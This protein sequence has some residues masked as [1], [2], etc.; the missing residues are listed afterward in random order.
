MVSEENLNM[1]IGDGSVVAVGEIGLVTDPLDTGEGVESKDSD[2]KVVSLTLLASL[3]STL[4]PISNHLTL[5]YY[6]TII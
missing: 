1:D 2:S 6:Y 3:Q 4:I 5:Y